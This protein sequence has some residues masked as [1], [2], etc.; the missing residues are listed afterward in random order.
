M[1]WAEAAR[2]RIA[3]PEHAWDDPLGLLL[4][5]DPTMRET[6]ALRLIANHLKAVESGD[7]NRLIISMPPQEGKSTLVTT[8]GPLWFL[9][10]NPDRRIAVVSYDQDLAD[11]F[12]RNIRKIES[13]ATAAA[14]HSG[15]AL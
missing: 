2:R 9:T 15:L 10:R 13:V 3:P 1:S 14:A 6:P 7:L 5:L 8:A 11:E 12:G 4:E